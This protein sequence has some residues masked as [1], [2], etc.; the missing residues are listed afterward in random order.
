MRAHRC[1]AGRLQ[2]RR[3]PA[4]DRRR[5]GD[6]DRSVRSTGA[7]RAALQL[8]DLEPTGRAA[9]GDRR[10]RRAPPTADAYAQLLV[11]GATGSGKTLVYLHAIA[12]VLA[13]GGRAIV[14]VPEIALTPQTAE[15]FERAFGERVAVLHSALS[16]RERYDAWQ[17]AA[18]GELDVIVGAR[19]AVFAPLPGVRMIVVDEEHE[20]S[21]RQD[22]VPRY[23]AVDVARERMRRAGGVVVLGSATP[24]LED[25]ARAKAGRFPL[26]RLRERATAQPLP[27]THVVDM[28]REFASRR[29]PDV[30]HA[31]DRSDRRTAGARREERAVRQSARGGALRALPR[32]A[33]TCRDCERCSTSLVLHRDEG[34]LRCHY[35]DAQRRDPRDLSGLRTRPD[36]AVRHRH[37]ARR[38]RSRGPLPGGAH[39]AHGRRHDDADRRSRAAARPLRARRR[40]AGRHADGRQG[41]RLSRSDARRRDRGRPRSA[42]RRLSRGRAHVR[43]HRASLRAQRPRAGRRSV[44][45]NV[46]RRRIR[47]SHS[48]RNTITKGSRTANS[49][50]AARCSWPPF[51]RLVFAGVVGRDRGAVEAAIERY[52]GAAARRCALG[53]AGSG[54]YPLA[55][56]NDEWRYRIAVKTRDLDALRDALRA[57]VLPAAARAKETR[58][59]DHL[60][61]LTRGRDARRCERL[62]LVRSSPACPA[63][64]DRCV[65]RACSRADRA[66]RRAGHGRKRT[67][68]SPSRRRPICPRSPIRS[69]ARRRRCCRRTRRR[70]TRSPRRC[71]PNIEAVLA[72]YDI[73]RSCH[74]ARPAR[75]EARTPVALGHRRCR[76]RWRRRSR[77]ARSKTSPTRN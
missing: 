72:G 3:D 64:H 12:R 38:G 36:R 42:R 28:T 2:R 40:R 21:Y 60:R 62:A 37:A 19:S 69:T 22:N 8:P 26:L 18:R 1:G 25:Y 17:A 51:V 43:R 35:C 27:A 16:E 48:P 9:R 65:A 23:H 50:N 55:R 45:P 33:A 6:R 70:S 58:L 52:A 14:L 41:P 47:R 61:S 57:L 13:R 20:S 74:A 30:Q 15:R 24:A 29:Q 5:R 53:G 32:R 31:A 59:V 56:L 54:A 10:D 77:F 76:P 71:A 39:R 66:R 49:P 11:H 75:T 7:R 34:R 46:Q 63:R 67:R 44:H 68:R 73:Q 4:R